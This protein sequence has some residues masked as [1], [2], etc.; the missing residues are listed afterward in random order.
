M[1]CLS[2]E[3]K[4]RIVSLYSCDKPLLVLHTWLLHAWL[5]QVLHT[6]NYMKYVYSMPQENVVHANT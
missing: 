4:R 6:V 2:I 3:A 1:P 5:L